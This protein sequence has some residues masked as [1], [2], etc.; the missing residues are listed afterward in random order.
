MMPYR[1]DEGMQE[2]KKPSREAFLDYVAVFQT[3]PAGERE[4]AL[5]FF[6]DLHTKLAMME[7]SR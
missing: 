6:S 1:N 5:A 2:I 3:M 7:G 4:K